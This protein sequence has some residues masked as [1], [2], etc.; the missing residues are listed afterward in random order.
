LEVLLLEQYIHY[1]K[2]KN[3][4]TISIRISGF[5]VVQ[6]WVCKTSIVGMQKS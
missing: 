1:L 3:E 2:I 6:C 4:K 5:D